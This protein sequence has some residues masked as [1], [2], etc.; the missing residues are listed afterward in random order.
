[1]TFSCGPLHMDKQGQD[2]KLEPIYNRSVP[3]QERWSIEKSAKSGSG[4]SVLAAW[5]DNDDEDI[6]DVLKTN[7]TDEKPR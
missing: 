2:D 1:M 4:R 6:H 7:T 5:H 3:I